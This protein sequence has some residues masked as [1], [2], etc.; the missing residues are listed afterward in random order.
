M[1]FLR[2]PGW[3]RSLAGWCH[4]LSRVTHKRL[5]AAPVDRISPGCRACAVR[6][7]H[8][9]SQLRGPRSHCDRPANASTQ[10]RASVAR[11]A[12]SSRYAGPWPLSGATLFAAARADAS[13]RPGPTGPGGRSPG[14]TRPSSCDSDRGS[15]PATPRSRLLAPISVFVST[16]TATP[17]LTPRFCAVC[18]RGSARCLASRCRDAAPPGAVGVFRP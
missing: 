11:G 10:R 15:R 17:F 2:M 5:L 8:E 12:G 16:R 7:G 9:S 6:I 14:V 1:P 3:L 13:A 4:V 18:D